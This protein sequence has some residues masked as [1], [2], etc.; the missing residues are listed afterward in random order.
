MKLL[1]LGGNGYYSALTTAHL[2]DRHELTIFDINDAPCSYPCKQVVGSIMDLA[3][4]R[5][6]AM[7]HDAIL[8]FFVGS[9]DLST[10]GM[11]NVMTVAEQCNIPHVVY[12][13]SG[14]MPFPIAPWF[15][16]DEFCTMRG[17]SADFWR[18]FFPIREQAG[19]FPGNENSEYFLNKWVCEEIGRHYAGRG[20][21]KFTA[22]RPGLLMHDDMTNRPGPETDR[23]YTP[24]FM[25]MTGH[26]MMR[27]LARLFDLALSNPP[28]GFAAYHGSNDTPYNNL[29]VAKAQKELG[30]TCLDQQPYL[31]FYRDT[32][33]DWQAARKELVDKGFPDDVIAGL[34]AFRNTH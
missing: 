17:H 15:S 13:S 12:T 26:I 25:L 10:M 29:S 20:Q 7:G 4:L 9:A 1:V 27:D 24:F 5:N 3:E 30:F 19:I 18:D 28:D 31:D 14:G 16:T 11:A 8:T 22:I 21:V 6:A 34:Y 32:R 23:N 33:M 2:A